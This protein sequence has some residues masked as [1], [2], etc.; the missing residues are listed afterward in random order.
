MRTTR[1]LPRAPANR[2]PPRRSGSCAPGSIR[3]HAGP[4]PPQATGSRPASTGR[5]GL[6]DRPPL[7]AVKNSGWPRNPIDH[8]VLARLEK[9]GLTPSPEADRTTLIRRL[10]LDLTGLPPTIAEVD[11]FLADHRPDAYER[12]VDRLL[13]SPHTGNAGAG[14]GSIG[15]ATPIPTATRKT[16]SGRSGPT[17]TGSSGPSTATCPSTASP[18]SRS[19]ATCFPGATLD[20]RIATGLPSQHD[21][22]RGRG[23]RR[24]GVPL[25]RDRS[26]ASNTTGTVWLGLTIG[27]AQCHSHKYDPITQREYYRLLA[28]LNNADE[29]EIEIPDPD[30]AR[31]RAEIEARISSARGRRWKRVI[32]R[33]GPGS[34]NVKMAAWEKTMHPVR[35]TILKPVRLVS[36]KHA[37]LTVQPD[38]SVLATRRQAEQRRLRGRPANRPQGDHGH[39]ARGAHRPEPSR[40]RSRPG[41]LFQVGDFLLTEFLASAALP[42][43]MRNR[44]P[45]AFRRATEDYAARG[46]SAALAIDGITDT[47]WSVNGRGRQAA[48]PPSSS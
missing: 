21:D 30:I 24:R 8:F 14:T 33:E 2:S 22:Q 9:E 17:A 5:S 41:P 44:K 42:G 29:P 13:A 20:Q 4:R 16:A 36:K 15:L 6:P 27:C 19:P 23:H 10:S 45:L 28:F 11:A 39:P 7:P 43:Q 47:G 32:P 48:S 40:R 18:S 46:R 37:T 38:G 26:T 12:L 35:W 31:Q 25:R 1:C 3:G 34:L